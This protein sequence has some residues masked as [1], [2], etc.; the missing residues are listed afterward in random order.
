M[1]MAWQPAYDKLF[2]FYFSGTGNARAA[3]QWME[4]RSADM[5]V[6]TTLFDI[7][8]T[9]TPIPEIEPGTLIGICSPTHGFNMAP[10]VLDFIWKFPRN[11]HKGNKVFLLNTRAG[12]KLSKVFLPGLSGLALFLPALILRSKGYRIQAY[13]PLDMP[14]N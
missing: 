13:R 5:S 2:V 1:K 8:K 4:A 9:K 7:P 10:L 6:N 11:K 3:A 12:M 14:S